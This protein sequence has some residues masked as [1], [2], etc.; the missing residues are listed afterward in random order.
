MLILLKGI[1]QVELENLGVKNA[2]PCS[3]GI[4]AF[5]FNCCVDGCGRVGYQDHSYNDKPWKGSLSIALMGR[6][7][8]S[9]RA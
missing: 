1:R 3:P 5:F 6:M 2:T 7:Y 8:R 4:Q 9:T